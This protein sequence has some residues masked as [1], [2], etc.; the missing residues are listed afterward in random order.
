MISV[1]EQ[2]LNMQCYEMPLFL[3]PTMSTL[4]PPSPLFYVVTV[5]RILVML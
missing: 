3:R 4:K 1:S 2:V 5:P